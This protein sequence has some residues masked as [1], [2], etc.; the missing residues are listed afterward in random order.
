MNL[1]INAIE[2]MNDSDE[3]RRLTV[4][5]ERA[6]NDHIKVSVCDT[7]TGLPPL[8]MNQIFKSFFTTKRD[9][10]GIGLSISSS[11][12]EEHGG[13]LWATNNP[14]RGASFHFTLPIEGEPHH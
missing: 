8:Q 10:V 11:I 14:S 13:R 6:E 1:M 12:I 7:G 4:V 2:A 3:M 9:S 5:S